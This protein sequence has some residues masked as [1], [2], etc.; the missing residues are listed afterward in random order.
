MGDL[1][2]ILAH[3]HNL[4]TTAGTGILTLGV[5]SGSAMVAYHALLRNYIDDPQS[6]AHHTA[7]IRKVLMGTAII[8]GVGLITTIAGKL[9]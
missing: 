4:V 9:L 2:T 6:V 7:S 5:P 8:G 1:S 3:I